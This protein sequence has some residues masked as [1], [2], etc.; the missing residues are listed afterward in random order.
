MKKTQTEKQTKLQIFFPDNTISKLE[1]I[2]E[3][4]GIKRTDVVKIAV[5]KYIDE[6]KK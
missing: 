3:D 4:M 6:Y 5:K 1:Q 2:G